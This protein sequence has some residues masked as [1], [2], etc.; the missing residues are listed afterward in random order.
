MQDEAAP[1][2]AFEAGIG[3]Q[4]EGARFALCVEIAGDGGGQIRQGGD[5]V[6]AGADAGQGEAGEKFRLQRGGID[7][8][9]FGR[10]QQRVG[11]RPV[12]SCAFQPGE[13]GVAR[14]HWPR[15]WRYW[16]MKVRAAGLGMARCRVQPPASGSLSIQP[17]RPS[18][19]IARTARPAPK[20]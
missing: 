12:G 14:A 3:R 8:G 10:D 19:R 2:A 11:L 9:A 1:V 20:R 6:M 7:G 17:P 15:S 13:D 18:R 4:A 16:S 5:G